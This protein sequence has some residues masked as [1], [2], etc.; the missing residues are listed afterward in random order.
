MPLHIGFIGAG[1]AA[2]RHSEILSRIEDVQITAYSDSNFH[3]ATAMAQKFGAQAFSSSER[4]FRAMKFDAIYICLPASAHGAPE[5]LAIK[6]GCS[7]FIEPPIASHIRTA[8]A[9]SNSIRRSGT[10]VC[11]GSAWRYSDVLERAKKL[12]RTRP[13][14]PIS[15][16]SGAWRSEND[17]DDALWLEAWPLFDLMRLLVGEPKRLIGASPN[18][19]HKNAGGLLVENKNGVLT[20]IGAHRSP[21]KNDNESAEKAQIEII[22][23]DTELH[24]QFERNAFDLGALSLEKREHLEITKL[25]PDKCLDTLQN[26]AFLRA[27]SEGKRTEI[28]C[29]YS[30][31]I[32]TLKFALSAERAM[33]S[34]KFL[35]V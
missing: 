6:N 7:L 2:L 17:T 13:T 23:T 29:N 5:N 16:V 1:S 4:M 32:K 25:G 3:L 30:E 8:T 14:A 22:R 9:I 11:V 28:R 27:I 18:S 24:L 15:L 10:V 26:L 33:S 34:A 21:L 31:A 20:H 12:L 19:A 35:E